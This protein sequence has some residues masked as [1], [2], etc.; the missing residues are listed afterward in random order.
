MNKFSKN[1]CATWKFQAS[2]RWL[3]RV[4]YWGPTHIGHHGTKFSPLGVLGP[5]ICTP[6]PPQRTAKTRHRNRSYSCVPEKPSLIYDTLAIS[7]IFESAYLCSLIS[8]TW[9]LNTVV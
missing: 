9:R 3:K 5:W 4:A 1:I 8:V 2:E 7:E 6:P